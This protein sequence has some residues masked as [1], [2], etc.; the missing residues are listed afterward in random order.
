MCHQK[1]C[2]QEH[3]LAPTRALVGCALARITKEEQIQ[4]PKY[5]VSRFRFCAFKNRSGDLGSVSGW[6]KNSFLGSNLKMSRRV[7]EIFVLRKPR[8]TPGGISRSLWGMGLIAAG[9][10]TAAPPVRAENP[11]FG[12]LLARAE[13]QAAAG[14]R[15]SP[16]GDNMTE[17]VAGM[18]DLIPTATTEQLSQL[19]AL[20][21]KDAL[22]SSPSQR[23]NA[24][25][26]QNMQTATA[27]STAPPPP[28]SRAAPMPPP[29]A[30]TVAPPAA[31]P[32]AKGSAQT[33]RR[34]GP[35]AFELFVRGQQYEAHG[36]VSGARRF[37]ASAAA[38]GHAAAARALGRLY[39][40]AYLKQMAL[41]GIDPDPALARQWYE[42]A[43][44]MGDVEAGPLLEALS[45]R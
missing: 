9:L 15:W 19:S 12:E 27:P 18:M 36:D 35:R 34:P 42:Q 10:V 16:P 11:T 22:R 24:E 43:V 8:D 4:Q 2:V 25:P 3:I 7:R 32:D 38:Q 30:E 14:H 20:L 13:T 41:G 44:A 17:T 21:E 26:S 23:P 39:D 1:S 5:L 45:M 37:F 28:V 33:T 31:P 6:F 29:P 40:P